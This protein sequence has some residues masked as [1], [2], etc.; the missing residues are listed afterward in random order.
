MFIDRRHMANPKLRTRH[1]YDAFEVAFGARSPK[2]K[3]KAGEPVVVSPPFRNEE[4][5]GYK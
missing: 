5:L 4:G 3:A 1:N 2:N